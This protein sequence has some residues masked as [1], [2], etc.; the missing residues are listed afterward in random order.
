MGRIEAHLAPGEQV[1]FR[2]RLHPVIFASTVS[3]ALFVLGVVALIVHRN[4][5]AGS[6][7]LILWLAGVAVGVGSLAPLYL[8]W[9]RSECVV[10]DRRVLVSTGLISVRTLEFVLGRVDARVEQTIGGRLLGYG[11]L[12]VEGGGAVEAFARLTQPRRLRDALGRRP[13]R[14][15]TPR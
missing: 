11:T 2:T 10:T 6:T 13:A 12:R 14:G 15:A 7:V 3:F 1:V 8:R 9:R 5:L 4:E